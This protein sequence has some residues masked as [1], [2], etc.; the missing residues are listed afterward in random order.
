MAPQK[1]A[2]DLLAREEIIISELRVLGAFYPGA[3]PD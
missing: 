3:N 1:K 2:A